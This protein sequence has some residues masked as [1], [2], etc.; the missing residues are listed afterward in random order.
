[1]RQSDN[2][3]R[4]T[5]FSRLTLGVEGKE[6]GFTHGLVLQEVD[7]NRKVGA[8][9]RERRVCLLFKTNWNPHLSSK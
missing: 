3:W 4:V 5:G 2:I 6:A 8:I 1:M 9:A 7:C